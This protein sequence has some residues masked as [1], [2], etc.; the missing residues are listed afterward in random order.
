MKILTKRQTYIAFMVANIIT[1]FLFFID[2]C[3][4]DFRWMKLWGNWV[5]YLIYVIAIWLV[6]LGL[7]IAYKL[8]SSLIKKAIVNRH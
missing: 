7:R 1:L 4:Y 2:E 5:V 8:L 3:Y 6:S